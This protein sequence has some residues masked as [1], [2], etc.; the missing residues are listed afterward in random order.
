V[1]LETMTNAPE[2]ADLAARLPDEPGWVSTR[3][4][5]L[6]G[7]CQV[8]A[9]APDEGFVVVASDWSVASIVGRPAPDLVDEAARHFH[10]M[11]MNLVVRPRDRAWVAPLVAGWRE[12]RVRLHTRHGA[13][14]PVAPGADVR[15]FD[16]TAL[17]PLDH[18]PAE[19]RREIRLALGLNA[20]RAASRAPAV[21]SPAPVSVAAA[22]AGGLAV[23]FCYPVW[24]TERWWDVA[25]DTLA[26]HR[27]RGLTWPRAGGSRSG[28]RSTTTPRRSV[29]PPGSGSR[30]STSW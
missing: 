29:S 24:Q 21:A 15:R 6:S 19:L 10:G 3:G 27:R 18:V 17:P 9:R 23:A 2:T 22:F 16:A 26:G 14:P 28:A 7:R 30:R 20:P 8:L 25:V 12:R 13:L 4:M 5:L 11:R 1:H